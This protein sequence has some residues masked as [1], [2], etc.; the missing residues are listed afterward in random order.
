MNHPRIDLDRYIVPLFSSLPLQFQHK[1]CHC[2][3]YKAGPSTYPRPPHC[4][5]CG[6]F[7]RWFF[8]RCVVCEKV[9]LQDFRTP[10][11]CTF[12]P[13]CWEHTQGREPCDYH[14][15]SLGGIGAAYYPPLG[16]NPRE[17]SEDELAGALDD[18]L[19]E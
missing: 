1:C 6:K 3:D 8:K 18:L 17:F 7:V 15:N 10:E 16:L 12:Y 5:N 9:F 4:R 11:F 13:T 14:T 19:G 2:G